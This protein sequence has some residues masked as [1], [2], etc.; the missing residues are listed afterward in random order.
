MSTAASNARLDTI[1][2][3]LRLKV[4][5]ILINDI[6]HNTLT[7]SYLSKPYKL[8]LQ[9]QLVCSTFYH[10]IRFESGAALLPDFFLANNTFKFK[11]LWDLGEASEVVPKS[12]LLRLRRIHIYRVYT[13][14]NTSLPHLTSRGGKVLKILSRNLHQLELSVPRVSSTVR[15]METFIPPTPRTYADKW[16]LPERGF[17]E[18]RCDLQCRELSKQFPPLRQGL[19]LTV[20]LELLGGHDIS[21]HRR[22]SP[23]TR[24]VPV[25]ITVEFFNPKD[26]DNV[27][28]VT[29]QESK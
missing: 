28:F 4:Y 22:P 14:D 25:Y 1:P 8:L 15:M 9:L 12:T 26:P 3:E 23:V 27:H 13:T 5:L 7:W 6:K 21:L 2:V 19:L 18:V 16:S 20:H 17:T 29:H 10:K 24:P 11:A